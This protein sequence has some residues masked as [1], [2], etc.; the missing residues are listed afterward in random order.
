[1]FLGRL[2]KLHAHL[3][4]RCHR[5][6]W[7]WVDPFSGVLPCQWSLVLSRPLGV[8]GVVTPQYVGL[9]AD[10]VLCFLFQLIG[11]RCSP[12]PRALS[13]SNIRPDAAA[14][15]FRQVSFC[16]FRR[17]RSTAFFLH[18]PPEASIYRIPPLFRR[19]SPILPLRRFGCYS[20]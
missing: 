18:V 11:R 6:F 8:V 2:I 3:V 9:W 17:C 19:V 20:G 15:G 1:M 12:Y 13:P 5:E 16:W 7:I 4:S 14:V 10:V